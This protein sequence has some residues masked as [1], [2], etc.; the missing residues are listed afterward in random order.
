[1]YNLTQMVQQIIILQ[2]CTSL[3]GQIV[4]WTPL[5]Q[6]TVDLAS[7]YKLAGAKNVEP[8]SFKK[9]LTWQACTSLQ[10]QIVWTNLV[11][12]HTATMQVCR[13]KDGLNQLGSNNFWSGKLVQ[14]C[15][16]KSCLNQLGSGWFKQVFDPTSLHKLARSR[17]VWTNKMHQFGST[18]RWPGKLAQACRSNCYNN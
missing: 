8:T 16:V 2:E 10:G 5:V 15:Q 18:N 7:L 17:R 11:H 13:V 14:A 1:M 4:V 9:L 12:F 3:P 6:H